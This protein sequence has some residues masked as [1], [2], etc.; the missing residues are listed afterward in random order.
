[1]FKII[2]SVLWATALIMIVYSGIYFSVKLKFVQFRF[3][4]IF[5]NLFYKSNNNMSLIDSLL[6][7][8]GG[9][10][11]VG[12]IAGTSI[13]ITLGGVGSIFW[14]VIIGII[15]CSNT[16]AEVVLGVK[17]QEYDA[18]NIYKGGPTY[19]IKNGLKNIKLSRIYAFIMLISYIIGTLSIQSNTIT[20]SINSYL[21][22]SPLVLGIIISF[23]SLLIISGGI[24]KISSAI[25]LIVPMM[26]MIYVITAFFIIMN[27]LN[28]IPSLL[29]NIVNEAFNFKALGFGVFSSMI[30]GV[31]RGIFSNEA[32]LGTGAIAASTIKVD[33]PARQGFVQILSTYITT[34]FICLA[35]GI[36]II[37]SNSSVHNINGI[38][39]AQA[40]FSYHLGVI[41]QIILLVVIILF[42]FST[43]LTGY[44]DGETN[45]KSLYGKKTT[46]LKI[47]SILI[48]FIGS[49]INASHIWRVVNIFTAILA[50]I[51]IYCLMKLKKDVIDELNKYDKKC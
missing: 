41:G 15:S 9:R 23:I 10:I 33:Y 44:Y 22:I 16:F 47:I 2:E 34:I 8:L 32:G 11:G 3:K 20:T 14:I 25:S 12:S 39:L 26:I 4:D 49:I 51:N 36:V 27:S 40:S 28:I 38:E 5:R 21:N 50:I 19:Y 1:M 35:T 37:S 18:E 29:S 45:F 6:L 43:I 31:Q 46:I 30:I 17:Y 13:A 42:A 48:I 24:K 7:V